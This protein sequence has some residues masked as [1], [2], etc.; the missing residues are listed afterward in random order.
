MLKD[1]E[2]FRKN[3]IHLLNFR[4]TS[5][6]FRITILLKFDFFSIHFFNPL[7][8]GSAWRPAPLRSVAPLAPSRAPF[9]Q[10]A[11]RFRL[12][13][14]RFLQEN[15]RFAAFFKIYQI[16]KLKFLK[17]M[18]FCKFCDICNFFA[19]ISRKLLFFQTDFLRKV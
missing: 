8:H 18:K 1:L 16:L 13:R 17:L 14:H 15:M 12:Y 7:R 11:A 19:E 5:G 6:N 2:I 4:K 10:N 3:I 9:R